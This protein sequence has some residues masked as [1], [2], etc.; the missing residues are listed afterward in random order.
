MPE[1]VADHTV[2]EGK[3]VVEK[4]LK[5]GLQILGDKVQMFNCPLWKDSEN[6]FKAQEGDNV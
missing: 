3:A 1:N 5:E 4:V 6:L 2:F